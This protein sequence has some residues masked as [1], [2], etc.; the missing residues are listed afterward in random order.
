VHLSQ[1]AAANPREQKFQLGWTLG[2]EVQVHDNNK[3]RPAKDV[4]R[5]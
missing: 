5:V 1:G 3:D 4:P 2:F